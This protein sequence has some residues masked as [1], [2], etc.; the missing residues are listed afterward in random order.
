MTP[1]REHPGCRSFGLEQPLDIGENVPHALVIEPDAI[2]REPLVSALLAWGFTSI[3][4]RTC[5]QAWEEISRQVPDLI[6]IEP[7]LEDEDGFRLV[8]RLLVEHSN[9]SIAVVVLT[10]C[11]ERKRV[12]EAARIGIRHY[13][14]KSNFEIERFRHRIDLAMRRA[15]MCTITNQPIDEEK[16]RRQAE[17]GPAADAPNLAPEPQH[18]P[19]V[20]SF[21][22]VKAVM[23]KQET[24]EKIEEFGQC[25]AFS[26]TF[27]FAMKLL[28]D[29]HASIDSIAAA[30]KRDQALAMRVLKAANSAG[31]ARGRSVHTVEQAAVR[32]GLAELRHVVLGV[33]VMDEFGGG[34]FDGF[35]DVM[36]FWEHSLATAL[37]CQ[38][39]AKE[40]RSMDPEEA[41]LVGL[42]H[43]VGRVVMIEQFGANYVQSLRI[44]RELA[45]PLNTVE[46][47]LFNLDHAD[48]AGLLFKLWNFPATLAGP[49][50][51]H[52]LSL[53]NL[54]H[55][56][57]GLVAQT[58]TLIA[59][60]RI[61]N[62][63][64]LGSSGD[65]WIADIQEMVA[66]IG[67]NRH[68]LERII[69]CTPET[70]D[71]LKWGL[72]A[73]SGI[74][75]SRRVLSDAQALLE[76][77]V[78][79]VP[80]AATDTPDPVAILFDRL[81]TDAGQLPNLIVA[82]LSSEDD[83][84]ALAPLIEQADRDA[85]STLPML[86]HHAPKI[87][88]PAAFLAGRPTRV[89]TLPRPMQQ[90]VA[91]ASSLLTEADANPAEDRP[92]DAA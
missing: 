89:I 56:H 28:N 50:S 52:H 70:V 74:T 69:K 60:D 82:R 42:L 5:G 34:E 86:V 83:A 31:Y 73:A 45:Q 54:K 37:I 9:E 20:Q 80:I 44:A 76:R 4:A 85:G 14:L 11:A 16:A 24:I 46:K 36:D 30:I 12:L 1:D 8:Q 41:F 6:V 27:T 55:I 91:H 47:R 2:V 62:T 61:A 77:P 33:A 75:C 13:L 38:Q 92:A 63:L 29:S 10:S 78:R 26:P 18:L 88:P 57:P 7:S 59:A 66:E 53:A 71:E 15:G 3:G 40:T 87:K 17:G 90:I 68:A 72:A 67:L 64:L 49:V 21:N 79:V 48:V 22:D 65:E 23:P 25:R 35:I 58:A 19:D 84:D 32:I 39:I 51:T 43:D 81:V